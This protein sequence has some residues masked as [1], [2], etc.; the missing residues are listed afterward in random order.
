MY[1]EIIVDKLEEGAMKSKKSHHLQGGVVEIAALDLPVHF[2][3]LLQALND[4]HVTHRSL[5]EQR[6]GVQ[7]ESQ[8]LHLGGLRRNGNSGRSQG[9]WNDSILNITIISK[10]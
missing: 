6:Q 7:L 2:A 1:C 8:R 10:V 3:S 9:F 5:Q 4:L